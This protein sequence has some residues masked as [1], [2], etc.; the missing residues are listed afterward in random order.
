MEQFSFRKNMKELIS[1]GIIKETFSALDLACGTGTYT[2]ILREYISGD[3]VGIDI[4]ENMV[5]SAIEIQNPEGQ[6]GTETERNLK[7]IQGDCFNLHKEIGKFDLVNACWLFNYAENE[8]ILRKAIVNVKNVMKEDGVFIGIIPNSKIKPDSW[9]IS[10]PF[11]SGMIPKNREYNRENL[12]NGE[13]ILFVLFEPNNFKEPFS[14]EVETYYYDEF[15]YKR[16]FEMAGFE[17]KTKEFV[18]DP[19]NYNQDYEKIIDIYGKVFTAKLIKT[20][21]TFSSCLI[22]N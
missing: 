20:E 19:E 6:G 2:R 13:P 5:K 12:K 18:I 14:F 10:E 11:G 3:I 8:E 17:I 1:E 22:K 7:F 4:S 21:D 16:A 9:K 15:T